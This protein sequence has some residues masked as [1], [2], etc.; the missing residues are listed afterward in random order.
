[1]SRPSVRSGS[2]DSGESRDLR[3]GHEPPLDP[4]RG[5]L[6]LLKRDR[7][8]GSQPDDNGALFQFRRELGA[9]AREHGGTDCKKDQ[10][11]SDSYGPPP[12]EEFDQRP[13]RDHQESN[14]KRFVV[15]RRRTADLGAAA[16]HDHG[17]QDWRQCDRVDQ[18]SRHGLK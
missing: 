4:H 10:G 7:R 14:D 16:S 5:E 1:M 12:D 11:N 3:D 15:D 18:R 8:S 9:E 2:S 17:A 13:V 6:A